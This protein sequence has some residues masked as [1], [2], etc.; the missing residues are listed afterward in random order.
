M[1]DEIGF[2]DKTIISN[3]STA[4][5]LSPYPLVSATFPFKMVFSVGTPKEICAF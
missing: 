5:Q 3:F 4:S 1:E 2:Q